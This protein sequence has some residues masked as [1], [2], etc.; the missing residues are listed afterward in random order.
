MSALDLLVRR[1]EGAP[2]RQQTAASSSPTLAPSDRRRSDL[3]GQ[4][5]L[6]FASC[7]YLGLNRDPRLARAACC[8]TTHGISPGLPRSLGT[9]TVTIALETAISRLVRQAR[10]LVFPSTQHAAA[11]VLQALAGPRGIIFVD[12]R[13][14]PISIAAAWGARQFGARVRL[15]P[16]NDPRALRRLLGEFVRVP[17]KVIVCDGVY[18]TGEIARLEWFVPLAQEHDATIYLD[19]AHGIGVLGARN[20]LAPRL[21][22]GGGGSPAYAGVPPG[23]LV[24]VAGMSKAF[25]TPIAFVAGPATF[26]RYL[27]TQAGSFVHASQPAL[28]VQAAALA[29]LEIHAMEGEERRAAL[30]AATSQFRAGMQRLGIGLRPELSLPIH[31]MIQPSPA[32][33]LR[34]AAT[35]R[36]RGLRTIVQ[37]QPPEMPT[38]AAL[39]FVLSAAHRDV[40][41]ERALGVMREVTREK[42]VG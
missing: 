35:L 12:E 36:Q 33:A 17:D 4:G 25:G 1:R 42:S 14:Y 29:A 9:S 20:G 6:D 2:A 21:G 38:G 41:I 5:L 30:S 34:L 28:P 37:S 22:Q 27:E 8:G 31:R 18:A 15:F 40:D 39:S 16:H 26:M 11:D 32:R 10:A 3:G 7:N 24:H 23:N 13:A 19:D